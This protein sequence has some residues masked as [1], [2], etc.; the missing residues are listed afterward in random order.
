MW[1]GYQRWFHRLLALDAI[2]AVGVVLSEGFDAFIYGLAEARG[3][4][5]H[6]RTI[7]FTGLVYQSSQS[8]GV[9][10]L[11]VPMVIHI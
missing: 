9:S 11:E 7:N 2:V 5:G 1:I 3:L 10:C 4:I 6:Q 8:D